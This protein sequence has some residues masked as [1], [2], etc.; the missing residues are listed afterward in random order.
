MSKVVSVI[1]TVTILLLVVLVGLLLIMPMA[2]WRTD[3][4]LSG[5]MEPALSAGDVILTRPAASGDVHVGDIVTFASGHGTVCHRVVAVT[6]SPQ[7]TY[8]TKGDANEEQ[9]QVSV[10][11]EKVTGLVVLK[12]P[13]IGYLSQFVKS[14]AGLVLTIL[15][16]ALLL[17]ILELRVLLKKRG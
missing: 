17:V 7:V 6:D 16:P 15:V 4:V 1:G 14:P 13:L 9:D 5:S 12:I 2:G 8:L 11:P 10:A 3:T